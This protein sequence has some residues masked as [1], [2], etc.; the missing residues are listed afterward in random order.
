VPNKSASGALFTTWFRVF[1]GPVMIAAIPKLFQIGFVYVQPFL[2]DAAVKLASEP[3]AQ[4][5]NNIGYGLVGAYAFVYT[6]IAVSSRLASSVF[7]C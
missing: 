7:S 3:Q 5:F 2:V 4:P 6:G 1:S